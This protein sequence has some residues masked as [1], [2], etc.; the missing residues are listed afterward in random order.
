[1]NPRGARFSS[2]ISSRFGRRAARS[3][4]GLPLAAV[5][6]LAILGGARI[7]QRVSTRSGAAEVGSRIQGA[8]L[9]RR[10]RDNLEN[11]A[12]LRGESVDD[13]VEAVVQNALRSIPRSMGGYDVDLGRLSVAASGVESTS[14]WLRLA[15]GRVFYDHPA[16]AKDVIMYV[17]LR[18]R[19][20]SGLTG[21]TYVAAVHTARRY[22]LGAQGIPP[23]AK[24]AV[25]AGAYIGYKAISYADAMG[26][27]SKVVAIEMMPD[28]YALL[29]RNIEANELDDRVV[30]VQ[31][32]L[33]DQTGTVQARQKRKQQST[34]ADADELDERFSGLVEVPMDTL[35]DVLDRTI[36]DSPI[37]FLN[38][39]VNG[40]EVE[41]LRGLGPWWGKVE[42][43]S[44]TSPYS[45]GGDPIRD[46]VHRLLTA[47]GFTVTGVGPR[48][49]RAE[50]NRS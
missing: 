34:I 22:M 47:H 21:D 7:R 9:P 3:A 17:L 18:D 38:V 44:V 2:R 27:D 24:V 11:L 19:V 42:S 20:P 4:R 49:I 10:N 12:G 45:A 5:S 30:P 39:Q 26:P 46:Q 32:A 48:A 31:S 35:A 28:N 29:A 14:P 50:K 40:A 6:G 16:T 23:G 36:G 37:D 15:N 41:A 1:M 8:K 33:S 13:T 25:D 43:I